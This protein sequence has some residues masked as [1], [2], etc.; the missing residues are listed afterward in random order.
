M[1]WGGVAG[2]RVVITGA[3]SG[4]GL[5]AAGELGRR[6]ADL[7]IVARSEER[8]R[9]AVA[10]FTAG[11][12]VDVLLADLSS[13]E[14]VR[15]LASEINRRYA[16]L[17][18]LI[19]NAGAIFSD[20]ELTPEGIERTWALN[21]LAPFLLTCLLL[22][23]LQRSAPARVITTSSEAHRGAQLPLS[24][25]VGAAGYGL[26][27]FGAYGRSK[28]ANILFT[29]ELARRCEGSGVEAYCFHPGFVASGFNRNNG[30]W[31][32]LGMGLV[33]PFAR[34][35]EKGAETLVWL[36]DVEDPEGRSGDYFV[37]LKPALPSPSGQDPAAARRLWELSESQCGLDS[38][39]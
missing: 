30:S 13:L 4:I 38:V 8:A 20:R 32:R 3:T 27:G 10:G 21:H 11:A 12:R 22:P 25:P 7:A 37:D 19:N 17:E 34:S 23:L 35:P 24:D 28:L 36:A 39:Q 29:R 16:R 1:A 31:M 26:M 5:A 33:R 15:S 14:S 6:G 9:A 2:K 18:V